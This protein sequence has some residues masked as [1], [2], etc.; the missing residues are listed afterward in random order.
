MRHCLLMSV[1]LQKKGAVEPIA[2]AAGWAAERRRPDGEKG[3]AA[4]P[5]NDRRTEPCS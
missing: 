2:V 5:G 4:A 1:N 3:T